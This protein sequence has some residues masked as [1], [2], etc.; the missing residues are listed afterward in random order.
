MSLEIIQSVKKAEEQAE[1]IRRQSMEESRR[2]VSEAHSKAR[3]LE[4]KAL[5]DAENEAKRIIAAAESSAQ[6][7]IDKLNAKVADECNGLRKEAAKRMDK[8]VEKIVERVVKFH[9]GS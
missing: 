3:Q 2:I 6:I 4:E 9:G 5:V 8:A 1:E 7:E